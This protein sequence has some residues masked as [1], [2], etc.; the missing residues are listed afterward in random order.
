MAKF[1][2]LSQMKK[3]TTD[4]MLVN[5]IFSHIE[6]PNFKYVSIFYPFLPFSANKIMIRERKP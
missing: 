3:I 1:V 2:E 6:L 4:D 5:K